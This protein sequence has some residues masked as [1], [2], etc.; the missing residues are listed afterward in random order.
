MPD[1]DPT[2]IPPQYGPLFAM[3]IPGTDIARQ[4]QQLAQRFETEASMLVPGPDA[5]TLIL[6]IPKPPMRY[7]I[8]MWEL[9]LDEHLN[10]TDTLCIL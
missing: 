2:T 3:Q 7:L 10:V 4:A 1:I 8:K 6:V 9:Q 5:W